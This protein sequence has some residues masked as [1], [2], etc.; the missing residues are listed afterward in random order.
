MLDSVWSAMAKGY[1]SHA[2]ADPIPPEFIGRCTNGAPTP[3][4]VTDVDAL[5][6]PDPGACDQWLVNVTEQVV[7]RLNV[8]TYASSARLPNSNRR[9]ATS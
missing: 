1:R 8:R 5:G 4:E 3:V 2:G 6:A 9:A 7:A